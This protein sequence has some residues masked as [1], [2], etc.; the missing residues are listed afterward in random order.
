MIRGAAGQLILMTCQRPGV[1][2]LAI[3]FTTREDYAIRGRQR[4]GNCHRAEPNRRQYRFTLGCTTFFLPLEDRWENEMYES[5]YA[6]SAVLSEPPPMRH[7]APPLGFARL[8][9]SDSYTEDR[10]F[11]LMQ[12]AYESTGGLVTG[13][14]WADELRSRFGQPI[15]IAARAIVNRSVVHANWH[16]EIWLPKFQFKLSEPS[17]RMEVRNVIGE[18]RDA[19]N[20][21]ELAVWFAEPNSWLAGRIPANAIGDSGDE[22]IQAARADRYVARG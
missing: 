20:D 21:W 14:K 22:V 18:L 12:T 2:I 19:F 11:V 5:L 15:S 16:G 13:N 7:A 4:S 9:G 3:D 17:V 6:S 1:L 8:A 10:E